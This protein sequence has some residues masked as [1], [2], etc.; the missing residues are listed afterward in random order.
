MAE[1]GS[2]HSR[3][4]RVK[5]DA[6][7]KEASLLPG[8]MTERTLIELWAARRD[9]EVMYSPICRGASVS[10]SARVIA[11]ATALPRTRPD[12]LFPPKKAWSTTGEVI[13]TTAE[14]TPLVIE[15]W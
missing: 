8:N 9:P 11:V 1:F 2:F 13:P 4:T 6:R 12:T 10:C 7:E 3:L 14:A 15:N 5:N